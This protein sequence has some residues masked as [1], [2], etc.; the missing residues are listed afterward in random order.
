M[1]FIRSAICAIA[2]LFMCVTFGCA[3]PKQ[4]GNEPTLSSLLNDVE[5]YQMDNF[6]IKMQSG[7]EQ[8]ELDKSRADVAYK[9]DFMIFSEKKMDKP[10]QSIALRQYLQL[11]LDGVGVSKEMVYPITE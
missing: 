6:S 8:C 1:K 4:I 7:L 10:Q 11:C 3:Q 2:V 5:V 9:S